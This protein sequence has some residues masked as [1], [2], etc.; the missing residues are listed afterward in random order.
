MRSL[1]LDYPSVDADGDFL[2]DLFNLK[3]EDLEINLPVTVSDNKGLELL[4]PKWL[5]GIF[6]LQI[7]VGSESIRRRIWIQ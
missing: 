1:F 5:S 2:A 7:Q 4:F 6:Y 3:N